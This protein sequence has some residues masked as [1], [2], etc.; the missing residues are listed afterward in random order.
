MNTSYNFGARVEN[1]RYRV[2][3][4]SLDTHVLPNSSAICL[5]TPHSLPFAVFVELLGYALAQ[6]VERNL[7]GQHGQLHRH[8]SHWF[9]GR[10]LPGYA[11]ASYR[12]P[13][14]KYL[15]SRGDFLERP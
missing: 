6:T 9:T 10:A 15:L 13:G 5:R 8:G 3:H 7:E 12:F 2:V 11:S 1:P 14:H 4:V